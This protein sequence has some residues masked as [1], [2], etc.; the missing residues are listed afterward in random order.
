[1]QIEN[2]R[3]ALSK[4]IENLQ[5][6]LK[7]VVELNLLLMETNDVLHTRLLKVEQ[8]LGDQLQLVVQAEVLA[9]NALLKGVEFEQ[10]L[11]FI[12]ESMLSP[13]RYSR[14]SLEENQEKIKTKMGKIEEMLLESFK[15]N[16][17]AN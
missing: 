1:M 13:H 7:K 17:S 16:I 2:K 6:E 8:A 3:Q 5:E 15:D 11:N 10:S 4:S 14:E 9:R 12:E